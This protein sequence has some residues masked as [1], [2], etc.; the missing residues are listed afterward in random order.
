[1][2][3]IATSHLPLCGTDSSPFG[4]TFTLFAAVW[5][6]L[7]LGWSCVELS[8]PEEPLFTAGYRADKFQ[9][10]SGFLGILNMIQADAPRLSPVV[11]GFEVVA[12]FDSFLQLLPNMQTELS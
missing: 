11:A 6:L 8:F 4:I 9:L 5:R 10:G 2:S 12:L 3:N 1:L 7:W